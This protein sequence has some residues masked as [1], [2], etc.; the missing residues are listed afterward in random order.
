MNWKDN[1]S[2]K[3]FVVLFSF[4]LPVATCEEKSGDTKH[5]QIIKTFQLTVLK[6]YNAY[7]SSTDTENTPN[8]L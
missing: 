3:A 1:G 7:N 5:V 6:K 8:T 4:L 2:Y